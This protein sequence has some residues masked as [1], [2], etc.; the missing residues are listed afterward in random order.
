VGVLHGWRHCPRCGAGLEVG[1]GRAECPECGFVAYANSVPTASAVLVDADGRVLLGRRAVEPDKGLWDLPG[2]FIEEGEHPLDALRRELREE[3]GLEIEPGEF[4]GVWMDR[5]GYDSTATSTL[6]LY[7]VARVVSGEEQAA[8]DVS[9]L[10]WFP[11]EEL[12]AELAFEVN[13]KVLSAW[14]KTRSR[15]L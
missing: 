7:W 13:A 3:T 6:N 9:E 14:R 15:A 5:Y 8:D 4:L 1:E 2:G 11:P 12:P 10:R